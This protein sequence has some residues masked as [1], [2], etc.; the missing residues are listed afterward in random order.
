MFT[1][2]KSNYPITN[3][4]ISRLHF[5]YFRPREPKDE[6]TVRGII[7]RIH[8]RERQ[9]GR[10]YLVSRGSPKKHEIA[11]DPERH[12]RP[13]VDSQAT[14]VML[15]ELRNG[16]LE[17][18]PKK[19]ILRRPFEKYMREKY[20]PPDM[21]IDDRLFKDADDVT[22]RLEIAVISGY[23]RLRNYGK[24]AGIVADARLNDELEYLLLIVEDYAQQLADQTQSANHL[25]D[26]QKLLAIF[27]QRNPG[28]R[29][30]P[31][32]ARA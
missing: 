22:A 21:D 11:Q 23:A 32:G 20:A 16:Y 12:P 3:A 25:L 27:G 4:E 24:A 9:F 13:T 29:I 6:D 10:D 7:S 19:E 14:A 8:Q 28:A 17:K 31:K 15:L 5:E 30:E 18:K 1:I 2:W 26:V